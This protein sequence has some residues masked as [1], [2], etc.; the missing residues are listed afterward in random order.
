MVDLQVVES[1]G[2]GIFQELEN[3]LPT[4]LMVQDGQPQPAST[5]KAR[6]ITRSKKTRCI[7]K[8]IS[9][10]VHMQPNN[11]VLSTR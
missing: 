1:N 6:R 11:K 5:H 8:S 9:G 2:D 3:R 10:S 7:N 4:L